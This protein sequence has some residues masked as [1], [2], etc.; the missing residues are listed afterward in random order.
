MSTNSKKAIDTRRDNGDGCIRQ[1]AD[2][3]WE[4]KI[5][6]NGIRSLYMQR[7]RLR[8]KENYVSIEQQRAKDIMRLKR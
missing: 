4:A 6:I 2:G 3:R 5:H 1:R 8:L 7:R